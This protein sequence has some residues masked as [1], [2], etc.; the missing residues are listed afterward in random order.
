[1]H[2]SEQ[3]TL[4]VLIGKREAARKRLQTYK[5]SVHLLA[6]AEQ[7]AEKS[8]S[9]ARANLNQVTQEKIKTGNDQTANARA[10]YSQ[11]MLDLQVATAEHEAG[12]Q[13]VLQA[14]HELGA[15]FSGTTSC[16]GTSTRLSLMG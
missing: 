6:E 4:A 16:R 1:M 2:R 9:S 11:A 3:K 12:K 13:V 14:E 7:L 8:E 10:L 15:S 5:H